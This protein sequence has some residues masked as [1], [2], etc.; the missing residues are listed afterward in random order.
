M[1]K[2]PAPPST[3][4]ITGKIDDLDKYIHRTYDDKISYYWR[5]S[6]WNKKNYKRYRTWTIVLGAL[7]TLVASLT[8]AQFITSNA[9]LS[10]LFTVGT[11]LLAATLTIISGLSQNFQ[12][13]AT[14]RD[15][16]VNAQRLETERDRFLAT[17]PADR[18]YLEE[19]QV[20][21]DLVLTET[22]SFFQRVLDSE[23]IPVKIK[24]SGENDQNQG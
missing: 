15:M 7:V 14:W 9:V 23:V 13:G 18:K 17:A 19:L 11:P 22:Q 5:S 10:I 8:T 3:I 24:R 6:T 12:W 1:F 20:I 4:T 21:N 2:K 16:T